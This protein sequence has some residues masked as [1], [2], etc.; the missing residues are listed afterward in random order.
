MTTKEIILALREHYKAAMKALLAINV[1]GLYEWKREA[2]NLMYTYFHTQYGVCYCM[3]KVFKYPPAHMPKWIKQRCT[4]DLKYRDCWGP[5]PYNAITRSDYL[6]CIQI[7]I[8]ILQAYADN[9]DTII[10]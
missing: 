6:Y 9:P 3:Q 5:L 2:D 10:E 7:R 4:T 1:K 8:N